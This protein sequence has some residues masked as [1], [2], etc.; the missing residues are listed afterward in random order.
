[1]LVDEELL[2]TIARFFLIRPV[3]PWTGRRARRVV[4]LGLLRLGQELPPKRVGQLASEVHD[5]GLEIP[6]VPDLTKSI[7]WG[8]EA[9]TRSICEALPINFGLE[10]CDAECFVSNLVTKVCGINVNSTK[11]LEWVSIINRSLKQTHCEEAHFNLEEKL[12]LAMEI[13][14]L[15]DTRLDSL[16][17]HAIQHTGQSTETIFARLAACVEG[18]TSSTIFR[19][20][21]RTAPVVRQDNSELTSRL[22]AIA[23]PICRSEFERWFS[24]LSPRLQCAVAKGIELT[25]VSPYDPGRTKVIKSSN[26]Y[27]GLRELKVQSKKQHYR[28]LYRT[29]PF[30]ILSFGFRRDLDTLVEHATRIHNSC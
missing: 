14:E 4:I 11:T 16:V 17:A 20:R 7:R 13:E 8:S 19:Q 24:G 5:M 23:H 25:E 15:L 27:L 1:M 10:E 21:S 26:S 9:I 6:P 30:E 29:A 3:E 22:S 12:Q 28:I 2:S 18:T